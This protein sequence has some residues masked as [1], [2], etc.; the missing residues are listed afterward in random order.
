MSNQLSMTNSRD[1][2]CNSLSIISGD[3][4]NDVSNLFQLL[5]N[6]IN[7]KINVV[8]TY[9]KI[10]IN[11]IL[12]NYYTQEQTS[13]LLN[14]KLDAT[15]ISNYYNK[16]ETDAFFNLRYTKTEADTLL[17]LKANSTD[18]YTKIESNNLLSDII[19]YG[20]F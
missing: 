11:A 15:E 6:Q 18:V 13:T 16:T 2:I 1:I 9:D 14:E 17:N 8:D 20:C 5:T 10:A 7:S 12:E 19:R 4:L 3:S